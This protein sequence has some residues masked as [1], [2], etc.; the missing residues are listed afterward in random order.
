MN[1]WMWAFG[2]LDLA[3]GGRALEGLYRQRLETAF[4]DSLNLVELTRKISSTPFTYKKVTG[5]SSERC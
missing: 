2:D 1:D 5:A 3:I 4:G